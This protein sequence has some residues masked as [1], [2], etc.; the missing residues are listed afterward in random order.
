MNKKLYYFAAV[1]VL[2]FFLW[3]DWPYY[4]QACYQTQ[5]GI[6]TQPTTLQLCIL[7]SAL[8]LVATILFLMIGVL[9]FQLIYSFF[10]YGINRI[11][12]TKLFY[13]SK[14]FILIVILF[15]LYLNHLIHPFMVVT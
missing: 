9:L 2:G 3:L 4:F 8:K 7:F 1:A 10:I 12:R 15:L 5:P 6:Y 14:L 11:F 13:R